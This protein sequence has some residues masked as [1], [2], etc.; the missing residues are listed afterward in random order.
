MALARLVAKA[1]RVLRGRPSPWAMVRGPG[2]AFVTSAWRL[3]WLVVDAVKVVTDRGAILDLA[4]DSPAAVRAEV[5][6]AVWRWRWRLVEAKTPG[7]ASSQSGL[8]A[9]MRP[10]WRL[11][12]A[13]H[14]DDW[15]PA[16]KRED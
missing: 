9:H 14:Q 15:G 7:V 12:R 11:L 4:R 1:R 16:E 13:R 8:G 3:G 6:D 2:A 10:L 5:A